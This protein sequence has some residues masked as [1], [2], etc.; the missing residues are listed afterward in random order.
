MGIVF[1]VLYLAVFLAAGFVL[2]RRTLP[3]AG[4]ETQLVF[5]AAFG[6]VL[7]IT[8]P[9]LFALAV[10]FTLPAALLALAA[11]AGI[12]LAGFLSCRSA[13]GRV[14][15]KQSA[16]ASNVS[17]SPS[18]I[19]AF[20]VCVLPL[21]LFSIWLLHT[22]TLYYKGGAYWCGQRDRKSVV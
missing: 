16:Q 2:A 8:L 12:S 14:F 15:R 3:A 7:L 13:S 9:A 4:P 22:H 19:P 5:T 20:W 10:G 1:S 17:Y 21:L 18:L 11:A 6:L